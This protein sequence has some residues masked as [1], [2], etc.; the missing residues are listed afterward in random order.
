MPETATDLVIE[1]QE[2]T[3]ERRRFSA[4]IAVPIYTRH[5]FDLVLK[6]LLVAGKVA[7][8]MLRL[9]HLHQYR[10]AIYIGEESKELQKAEV[11]AVKKSQKHSAAT[12]RETYNRASPT[13]DRTA[14]RRHNN[15]EGQTACG[16]D[17]P[18]GRRVRGV[19]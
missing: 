1:C 8:W 14:T 19:P 2:T 9:G 18:C 5:D 15:I 3:E 17:E 7:K 11:G 16:A 13:R 4:E 10:L 12:A 6:D